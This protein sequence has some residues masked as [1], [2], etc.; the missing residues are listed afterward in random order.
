MLLKNPVKIK[1]SVSLATLVITLVAGLSSATLWIVYREST[2]A[3]IAMTERLFDEIGA[4]LI[5]KTTA[6]YDR[7]TPP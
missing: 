1:F 3:S 2:A 5:E 6:V 4:R 7:T